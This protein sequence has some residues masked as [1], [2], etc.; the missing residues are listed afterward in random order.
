LIVS[1]DVEGR[2]ESINVLFL[3]AESGVENTICIN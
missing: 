1:I 2:K 3:R